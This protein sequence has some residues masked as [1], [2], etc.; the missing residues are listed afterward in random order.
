MVSLVSS[1]RCCTFVSWCFP[2]HG[3]RFEEIGFDNSGRMGRKSLNVNKCPLHTLP[4]FSHTHVRTQVVSSRAGSFRTSLHMV[5][6]SSAV[7][8]R[9]SLC[10]TVINPPTLKHSAWL[11]C[12]ATD[13]FCRKPIWGPTIPDVECVKKL[14]RFER[15]DLDKFKFLLRD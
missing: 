13:T 11:I 14:T 5:D 8:S 4:K 3:M 12:C 2:L 7:T 6:N 15:F 1:L 10:L 9:I